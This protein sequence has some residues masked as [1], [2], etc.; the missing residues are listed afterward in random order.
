MEYYIEIEKTKYINIINQ[1]IASLYTD[2]RQYNLM[3]SELLISNLDIFIRNDTPTDKVIDLYELKL[4]NMLWNCLLIPQGI[5]LYLEHNGRLS[6][7][8]N[9]FDA[10]QKVKFH[11]I[12]LKN[13]HKILK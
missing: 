12:L 7:V 10:I 1:D 5:Y 11:A 8:N 4:R 2:D 3:L 6:Y 13:A 9:S